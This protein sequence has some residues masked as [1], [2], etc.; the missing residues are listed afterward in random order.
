VLCEVGHLYDNVSVF[1]KEG[2]QPAVH[3]LHKFDFSKWPSIL[4]NPFFTFDVSASMY[5][6]PFHIS[7][8]EFV[9]GHSGDNLK[10]VSPLWSCEII[11]SFKLPNGLCRLSF[12]SSLEHQLTCTYRMLLRTSSLS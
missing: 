7:P 3:I 4:A 2:K 8:L 12:F 1:V 6:G 10:L 11:P 5:D 9:V